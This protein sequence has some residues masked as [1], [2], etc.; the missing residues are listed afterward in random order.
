M[1]T[2]ATRKPKAFGKLLEGPYVQRAANRIP[3]ALIIA[4]LVAIGAAFNQI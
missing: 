2:L 3:W 1:K 4:G